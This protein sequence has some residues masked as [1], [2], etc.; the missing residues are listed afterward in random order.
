MTP[1][2]VGMRCPE[3]ASQ[4]TKVM[5][6]RTMTNQGWVATQALI[7]INV[8]I[9]LTEGTSAYTLTGTSNAV[10]SWPLERGCL[11]A[12][13]VGPLHQYYRLLTA[14]FLHW[15]LLHIGSNMLV[16]Y[17]VGRMLE[18]VI[19][20]TRFIA[21]YFVGLFGGSLGALLFSPTAPTVG[22][23][24]AIFGLLGAAFIELRSRGINPWEAGIGGTIVLN[25]VLSLSITGISI[26][27]HIGGLVGGALAALVW[28]YADRHRRPLWIGITG[29]VVLA[30]A[31][32]VGAIIFANTYLPPAGPHFGL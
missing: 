20:R 29:S 24:G 12:P 16:L 10:S 30:A 22:A 32:I 1:T 26:G 18:P 31:A 8:V 11:L 19:G 27:G 23:S 2:R 3:C 28:Q 6:M 9:F 14:G 21:I 15:D 4:K 13:F 25:I 17:F 7:L 5:T